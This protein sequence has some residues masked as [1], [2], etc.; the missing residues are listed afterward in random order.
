MVKNGW[1]WIEVNENGYVWLKMDGNGSN[2]QN[3]SNGQNGQNG[4]KWPKMAKMA[5]K[6]LKGGSELP[7]NIEILGKELSKVKMAKNGLK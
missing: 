6:R 2:S 7:K 3:G 5:K 4:Q 1:K